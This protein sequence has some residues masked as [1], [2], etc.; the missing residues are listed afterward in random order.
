MMV[1]IWDVVTEK[2]WRDEDGQLYLYDNED[3][4]KEVMREEGYKEVYI[5][6]GV[7]FHPH[8]V[9]DKTGYDLK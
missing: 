8:I 7:E 3:E 9:I 2:Y 6:T 5:E 1:K 4:A